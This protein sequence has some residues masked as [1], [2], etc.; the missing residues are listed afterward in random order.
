MIINRTEK[1]GKNIQKAGYNGTRT[2]NQF[3]RI[4]FLEY[5]VSLWL[6]S[7]NVF[8]DL[9]EPGEKVVWN[10]DYNCTVALDECGMII[11][12]YF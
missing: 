10:H 3:Q 7:E 9:D 5:E 8:N 12:L 2:V 1:W 6:W 11:S 4:K